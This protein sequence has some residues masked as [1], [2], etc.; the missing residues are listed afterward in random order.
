MAA[1]LISG[2]DDDYRHK[3][4][5]ELESLLYVILYCCLRWL[6]HTEYYTLGSVIYDFFYSSYS[7]NGVEVGGSSKLAERRMRRI[8]RRFKYPCAPVGEWITEMF[9]LLAPLTPGKT[10]NWNESAVEALWRDTIRCDLPDGDRVEH[11][12]DDMKWGL[13]RPYFGTRTRRMASSKR[14]REERETVVQE[15]SSKRQRLNN[16]ERHEIGER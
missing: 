11:H 7:F 5:D 3:F 6:P 1:K 15:R 2:A 12:I 8:T 10:A 9:E 16:S 14:R 13:P 4:S